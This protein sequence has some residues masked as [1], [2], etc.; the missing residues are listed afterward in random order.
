LKGKLVVKR[1]IACTALIMV[2]A[3]PLAAAPQQL[4]GKSIV[5]SMST[6][7]PARA[8]DGTPSAAR[9]ITVTFYISGHGRAFVRADHVG[10]SAGRPSSRGEAGPESRTARF[11]G[12][13]LVSSAKFGSGASQ[14]IVAFD[15]SYRTCTANVLV[16]GEAGKAFTYIG[17]NGKRYTATGKTVVSNVTCA[18][19]DGNALG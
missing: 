12:N 9:S 14:L 1:L 6:Y 19:R 11:N 10:S 7:L 3:T 8:D 2:G 16:G 17:L 15:P 13:Q 5:V 18:V 4:L